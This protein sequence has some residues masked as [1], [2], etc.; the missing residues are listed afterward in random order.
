L[1]YICNEK[2]CMMRDRLY[3]LWKELYPAE[4][5]KL[6]DNFLEGIE[7]VNEEVTNPLWYRDAIV[8]AL[9][10]DLFNNDFNGLIDKLD[11]LKELGVNVLWLLPILDSPMR[12]DQTYLV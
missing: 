5:V 11:Y 8:Y 2:I 6:L 4:T 12:Y 9:Y 10:V 7:P 3:N 1:G